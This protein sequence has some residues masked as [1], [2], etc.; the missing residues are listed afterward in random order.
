LRIGAAS[1]VSGKGCNRR[2]SAV[3]SDLQWSGFH[4]VIVLT[5][6]TRTSTHLSDHPTHEHEADASV[7]RLLQ[8]F[9]Q[10]R[11]RGWPIALH[12]TCPSP[13]AAQRGSRLN[14]HCTAL[15]TVSPCLQG[16]CYLAMWG[17]VTRG[18]EKVTSSHLQ[19]YQG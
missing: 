17:S 3:G 16:G 10:Y 1:H 19:T 15:F 7:V 18:L 2:S 4:A 5:V 9:D 6:C 13:N 14:D 8:L 11:E 12:A